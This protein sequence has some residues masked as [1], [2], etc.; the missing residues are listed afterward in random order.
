VVL[1]Y[2]C[3]MPF[4]HGYLNAYSTLYSVGDSLISEENA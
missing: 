1:Q 3:S 4:G 2:P